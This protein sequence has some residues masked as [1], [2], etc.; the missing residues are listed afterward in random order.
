MV[1]GI[2]NTT[3]TDERGGPVIVVCGPEY[4]EV[5]QPVLE[6]PT[7]NRRRRMLMLAEPYRGVYLTC[8]SCGERFHSDEG[9]MERPFRR[10]WRQESI[11]QAKAVWSRWGRVRMTLQKLKAL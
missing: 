8:L 3:K 7:C 4:V 1:L 10:G 9:R 5:K 11:R 2:L 6:C